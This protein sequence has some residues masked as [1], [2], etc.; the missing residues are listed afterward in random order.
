MT[1]DKPAPVLRRESEA[2]QLLKLPSSS[3][4]VCPI[5]TFEVKPRG[6]AHV[7]LGDF[8]RDNPPVGFSLEIT[9]EGNPED[10]VARITKLSAAYNEYELTLHVTND[11]SRTVSVDVQELVTL[12]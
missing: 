9:P 8:T 7:S 4:R 10:V 3:K 1:E 12:A 5:V 2:S 11:S 6:Q